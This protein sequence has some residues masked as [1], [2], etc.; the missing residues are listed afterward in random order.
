MWENSTQFSLFILSAYLDAGPLK[1][2]YFAI[3]TFMYILITFV[4]TLVIVLI[5]WKKCLHEPMYMFLASLFV[6]ELYGSTGL[7]PLL[8]VQLLS[9]THTV[10]ASYCFTQIFCLYTYGSVEFCNLAVMAYDR[11]LAICFPL[12]YRMY[13]PTSKVVV[14]ITLMWSY[15]FIKFF[16]TFWLSK[17]LELCGNVINSVYCHNYLVVKLACSSS[18]TRVNDIYG[19][20][21]VVWS[22]AVPLIP[23]VFSYV[24]IFKVCLGASTESRQKAITTCTPHLASLLNFSFGCFFEI[25][26]SRFDMTRV[27]VI[28]R[29]LLSLYF[30]IC[31]PLFN[32]IVYGMSMS[33]IR[34][35]YKQLLHQL[36]P[37]SLNNRNLS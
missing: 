21:A 22:V 30:L 11:Y 27:P 7:F 12:Q 33:K 29:I 35:L 13:M 20:F 8:M 23:I 16:I 2:L 17:R 28:L 15:C 25:L 5:C 19:L 14:L 1:Y 3:V 10:P 26:Q 9:E 37:R 34:G 36:M 24:A 4:N 31:Q 32:P 18:E 6:N